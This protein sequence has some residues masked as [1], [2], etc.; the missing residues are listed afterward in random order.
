M[1][2][3]NKEKWLLRLKDSVENHSE[4]LPDS[5]WDNL[6]KEIP[7]PAPVKRGRRRFV[8]AACA[9]AAV[10]LALV[11]FVP[12]AEDHSTEDYV[13]QENV[14]PEKDA[15]YPDN[16][17][18]PVKENLQPDDVD[19]GKMKHIDVK[20]EDVERVAEFQKESYVEEVPVDENIHVA[21][22]AV[23]EGSG[24]KTVV[25]KE[26]KEPE[27]KTVK[28]DEGKVN[29]KEKEQRLKEREEYLKELEYLQ[30]DGKK[31]SR[32]EKH[33]TYLAFAAGNSGINFDSSMEQAPA[34][35][36]EMNPGHAGGGA[37]GPN[38][39][40]P[41]GGS[42][43]AGESNNMTFLNG[44]VNM[45][46]KPEG[47]IEWLG[48]KS[49]NIFNTVEEYKNYGYDHSTPV[50]LGLSVAKEIR[51]GLYVESGISYQ[52]MKSRMLRSGRGTVQKLHYLGIPLK[53]QARLV[54][55]G[56]F[57]LYLSGGYLLEKCIY[58]VLEHDDGS[59]E[60]LNV[61]KL[62]N[63]LNAS[64]GMQLGLGGGASLY[65]EP[66]VYYYL[67]MEN[68][69]IAKDKGYFIK[70]RYSDDPKGFSFQGGL[71]FSF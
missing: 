59:D 42:S 7:A 13:A 37:A 16:P 6:A 26:K 52:Y 30:N 46:Y 65:I 38:P 55:G 23:A 18:N 71:R 57:S 47:D 17:Y 20:P 43:I 9:V 50:R 58:G 40:G 24:E 19:F 12:A 5:F 70:N 61:S 54:Q 11:L 29:D 34:A 22:S 60:K 14:Q 68:G 48:S 67:G 2:S 15:Q 35:G 32:R 64:I 21:G 4:P 63:S 69:W 62:Q 36:P 45:D 51:E 28:S 39:G 8:W 33:R 66:G 31:E 49:P 3:E 27:E 1:G 25:E 41:A 44:F 56:S 53:L 10:V